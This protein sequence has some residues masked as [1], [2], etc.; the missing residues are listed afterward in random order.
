MIQT[1]EY[2]GPRGGDMLDFYKANPFTFRRPPLKKVKWMQKVVVKFSP[3]CYNEGWVLALN[4]GD[5]RNDIEQEMWG[6]Q[7]KFF[8]PPKRGNKILYGVKTL[9]LCDIGIG[10]TKAE[11][12][13]TYCKH[14]W[15]KR[16]I[17]EIQNQR[18]W[19]QWKS[20][21]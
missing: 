16:P 13:A 15:F 12:D 18:F 7:I 3:A 20:K 21:K 4:G 5:M 11:A 19:G 14:D 6:D 9:A 10:K 17:K 2:K 1:T 8:F